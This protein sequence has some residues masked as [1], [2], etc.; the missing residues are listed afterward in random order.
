MKK[1]TIALI[2]FTGILFYT[3]WWAYRYAIDSPYRISTEETRRRLAKKQFDVVLDVRTDLEVKTLGKYPGSVHIPAANINM[4]VPARYPDKLTRF[5][6]YCN[7][8]QRARA[9]ADKLQALGYK[10]A[11]YYTGSYKYLL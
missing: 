7:T 3:V 2:I 5:L 10:N 6:L 8:G 4:I 9:A 1:T 11:L